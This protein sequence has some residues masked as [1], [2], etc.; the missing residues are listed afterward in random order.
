LVPVRAEVNALVEGLHVVIARRL[1]V[2]VDAEVDAAGG[3]GCEGCGLVGV[4]W[5]GAGDRE[6]G[7]EDKKHLWGE[8]Y[9]GTWS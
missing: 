9:F 1:P 3:A 5:D 2:D 4:S 7:K 6:E 8:H